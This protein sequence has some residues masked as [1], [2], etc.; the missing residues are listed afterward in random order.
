MHVLAACRPSLA[1]RAR[2]G[3]RHVGRYARALIGI[4]EIARIERHE[5]ASVVLA[6]PGL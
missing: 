1:R 6:R 5:N 2:A 4:D 3:N